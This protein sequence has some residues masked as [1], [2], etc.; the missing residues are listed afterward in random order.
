MATCVGRLKGCLKCV[1]R[2]PLFIIKVSASFA[3]NCAAGTCHWDWL[4]CMA[5]APMIVFTAADCTAMHACAGGAHAAAA[6]AP[7]G[8]CQRG[9]ERHG[10]QAL[11]HLLVCLE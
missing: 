1:H 6:A 10:P 7:E 9:A 11:G 4:Q 8:C 5:A 3:A 2:T